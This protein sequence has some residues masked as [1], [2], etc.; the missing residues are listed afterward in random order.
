MNMRSERLRAEE[1]AIEHV[2]ALT[3]AESALEKLTKEA[4]ASRREADKLRRLWD[5]ERRERRRL[6]TELETNHSRWE[7][8]ARREWARASEEIQASKAQLEEEWNRSFLVA[9]E[10]QRS[11]ERLEAEQEALRSRAAEAHAA[12]TLYQAERTSALQLA[13]ELEDCRAELAVQK[14]LSCGSETCT[15]PQFASDFRMG[16]SES[17][18]LCAVLEIYASAVATVQEALESEALLRASTA[19]FGTVSPPGLTSVAVAR[20]AA[21][22][23]LLLNA[24]S[25]SPPHPETSLASLSS[26]F[27]STQAQNHGCE[28]NL[29]TS[30]SRI[31]QKLPSEELRVKANR[32][33]SAMISACRNLLL[34]LPEGSAVVASGVL[35][36]AGERSEDEISIVQN[37]RRQLRVKDLQLEL[38]NEALAIPF[39]IPAKS[40][41]S[42]DDLHPGATPSPPPASPAPKV[43]NSEDQTCLLEALRSTG[44][45]NPSASSP[46][47]RAQ[48][49]SRSQAEEFVSSTVVDRVWRTGEETEEESSEWEDDE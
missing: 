17:C 46:M 13:R 15:T 45:L 35:S 30:R 21:A 26:S 47:R 6:A 43:W 27:C 5:V 7:E 12:R 2:D 4:E 41:T 39:R 11:A 22:R 9:E 14:M 28:E 1:A 49:E 24:T 16:E 37:L 48:I 8:V 20:A 38:L 36:A 23:R 3:Q 19:E 34:L 42:D 40:S 44:H 25:D 18:D 33:T 31:G 29:D 32:E 10:A